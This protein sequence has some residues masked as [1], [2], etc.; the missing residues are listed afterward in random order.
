MDGSRQAGRWISHEEF[1]TAGDYALWYDDAGNQRNDP[2]DLFGAGR[3]LRRVVVGGNRV[4]MAE[5]HPRSFTFL[6]TLSPH[7]RTHSPKPP[8]AEDD[9]CAPAF[10]P[11]LLA[12]KKLPRQDSNLD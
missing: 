5:S 12:Y 9:A 6:A 3:S 4:Q 1:L 8:K 10:L 11:Q 7:W 2:I